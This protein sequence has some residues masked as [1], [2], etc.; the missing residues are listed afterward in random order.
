MQGMAAECWHH[1]SKSGDGRG[2]GAG[3]LHRHEAVVMEEPRLEAA[4]KL[5]G[6]FTETPL[7]CRKHSC[8]FAPSAEMECH[9]GPH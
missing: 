2:G 7:R 8:S 1:G 9:V 6:S 4:A 5:H 3:P